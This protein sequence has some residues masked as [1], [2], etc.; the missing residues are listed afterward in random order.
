[1]QIVIIADDRAEWMKKED[2]YMACYTRCSLFKR[3]ASKMGGNCKRMGGA[4]I[5]KLKNGGN[6]NGKQIETKKKA[7][8]GNKRA[9]ERNRKNGTR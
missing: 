5:P 1:M 8:T 4:E 3:C 6:R 2:D 7:Q 9:S